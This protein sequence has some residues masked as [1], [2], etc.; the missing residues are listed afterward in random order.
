MR[1]Y[2]R[3][4]RE[5]RAWETA[6]VVVAQILNELRTVASF[7]ALREGY[8]G[9]DGDWVRSVAERRGISEAHRVNLRRFEDAAY[10]LRWLELAGGI[11]LDPHRSLVPQIP[12]SLTG[13]VSGGA[14]APE[15]AEAG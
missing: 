15:P 6:G 14:A 1:W 3:A 12:V 7:G 8:C 5:Q 2:R 10:G 11:R 9:H 4:S 13:G